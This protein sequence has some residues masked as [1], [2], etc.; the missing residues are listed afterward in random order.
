MLTDLLVKRLVPEARL[1]K[2]IRPGDA[3]FDLFSVEDVTIL[4]GKRVLVGTGI[5]LAIPSGWVGLI[6]DR[7]GL[8]ANDGLHCLGGVIDENYRGEVKVILYNTG[9]EPVTL[10]AGSRIAQLVVVPYYVGP[11]KE[12]A[13][14]PPSEVR[15][16]AGFG[17]SGIT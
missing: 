7:S 2:R 10:L 15:G 12:V 9:T 3:G 17:S 14:L 11:I 5:A 16:V 1:P 8:A 13:E 4:P 6:K